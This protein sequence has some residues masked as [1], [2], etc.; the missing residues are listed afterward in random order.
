MTFDTDLGLHLPAADP[1][2]ERRKRWLHQL[3]LGAPDEEF[4]QFS[5]DLARD[6]GVPYGMVN[7]HT[8]FQRFVG[9]CSPSGQGEH[10]AVGRVMSRDHG[11][12]PEVLSRRLAL[13]LPDV[14]AAAQFAS[15]PVVD[16]IGIRT[17][18]GAPLIDIRNDIALGTVCYVGTEPRDRSTGDDALKFIKDRRDKLMKIIYDRTSGRTPQ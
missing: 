10:P 17:Y 1:D 9:L 14:M 11:Y 16:Q 8:D 4:D 2:L 7:L 18:A 13:V 3:G 15:N 6:A 12:C 5:E